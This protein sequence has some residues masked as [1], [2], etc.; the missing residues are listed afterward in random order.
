VDINPL[1]EDELDQALKNCTGFSPGPDQIHNMIW[2]T[3]EFPSKWTEAIVIP[4]LKPGKDPKE[5]TSYRSISLTSCMCK[6]MKKI[7]NR[8][9]LHV[10]E[11]KRLQPET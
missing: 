9:L 5:P 1:T 3:G 10:I 11:E 7:I 2:S 6:T 8:R 4:I